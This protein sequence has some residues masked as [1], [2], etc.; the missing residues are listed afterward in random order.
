[1]GAS[2]SAL[3]K[4]G[5]RKGYSLVGCNITGSNAFFVRNELV[6]N[7]FD[8]PFTAENHYQPPRYFLNS[9]F[10]SGHP[11]ITVR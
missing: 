6:S 3:E 2:L 8:E 7:Q 10:Y 4:L 1:M 11:S 5:L 9:G